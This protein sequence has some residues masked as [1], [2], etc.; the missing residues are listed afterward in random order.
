MCLALTPS[1]AAVEP[2]FSQL[3]MILG[4]RRL[5][6]SSDVIEQLLILALDAPTWDIFDFSPVIEALRSS[7][8]CLFSAY[9]GNIGLDSVLML[10]SAFKS[11]RSAE[12]P[13]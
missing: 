4:D 5:S 8:Q 3:R 12:A 7:A 2:A 6:L 1:D 10:V 13:R 11:G 9:V